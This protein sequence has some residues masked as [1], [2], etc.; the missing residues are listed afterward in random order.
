QPSLRSADLGGLLSSAAL[1][2]PPGHPVLARLL[3]GVDV[4][5][6]W[7]IVIFAV[8]LAAAADLKRTKAVVTS[9]VAVVLYLLVTGL[10]MGGGGPPPGAGS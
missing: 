2:V 7:A 5:T 9:A 3:G 1:P 8:A 4:F 10:I 6:C